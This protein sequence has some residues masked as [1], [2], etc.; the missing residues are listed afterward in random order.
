MFQVGDIVHAV[1]D[2]GGWARTGVSTSMKGTVV[3]V[4]GSALDVRWVDPRG[5]MFVERAYAH[6]VF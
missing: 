3:A 6:E 4:N 2:F 5:G 1:S